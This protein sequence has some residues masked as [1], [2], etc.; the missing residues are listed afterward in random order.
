MR[1]RHNKKMWALVAVVLLA[2][3]ALGIYFWGGAG[4]TVEKALDLLDP[5]ERLS[6][7]KNIVVLGVD[8]RSDDV[9][10]SDTLFVVMLDTK[11]DNVSLLSIPRDTMVKI[12]GHGWDKINH[13]YAFGGHK[14]TQRTVEQLLGIQVNNYVLIDFQG[15]KGLVDAIG[16]IDLV[17]EKDMSYEDPY[18]N[19]VIDLQAGPRHLDGDT[20]IQY[21][22]YRDEEGDIGRIKRQQHFLAAVYEKIMSPEVIPHLPALIKEGFAM[23]KT[24]IPLTDMLSLGKALNKTMK[25]KQGIHMAMVPGEPVDI[26]EISY[27]VPDMTDLRDLMVQMQ[28][29]Q[30]N[31]KYRMAA[32]KFEAEYKRLLPEEDMVIKQDENTDKQVKALSKDKLKGAGRTESEELLK[33]QERGKSLDQTEEDGSKKMA[34]G[35]GGD[36]AKKNSAKTNIE[37]TARRSVTVTIINGSGNPE[38]TGK[39][40]DLAEAAGFTVV[41][42]GTGAAVKSTE[43]VATTT[44]SWIVSKLSSLPFSYALRIAKDSG[45]SADGIIYLGEDF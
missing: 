3:T 24:D 41:G 20:A 25:D 11:N 22:R 34:A 6:L 38:N 8:E 19:L 35:S 27:W 4:N 43:V 32:E 23:I 29:A 18:D 9:G 37:K 2:L 33:N 13:A 7:K 16:G 31:D 40:I 14:L 1:F 42:T 36:A 30:M 45:A 12:Q 5:S 10:R 26:D 15:F 39:A 21:V 28:G 44:D 17:V